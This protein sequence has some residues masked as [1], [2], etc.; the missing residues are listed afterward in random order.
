MNTR[1]TSC[2]IVSESC[3]APCQ[4]MSKRMSRPLAIGRLDGRARRPVEIV[5]DA[6]PFQ[7]L[8]R[9]AHALEG[10]LVDEVVVLAVD[11][12]GPGRPRR[13]RHRHGDLAVGLDQP[14][15]QRRLARRPEG[16]DSTKRS[17]RRSIFGTIV[18]AASARLCPG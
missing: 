2:F 17:P 11:L 14:P 7:E 1:T 6:R 9:L 15:R 8:A 12:A 3:W 5:E 10:R 13:H 4:S 16:E 18:L